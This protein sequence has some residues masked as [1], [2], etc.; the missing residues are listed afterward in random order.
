MIGKM[1]RL[2][3]EIHLDVSR[4]VSETESQSENKNKGAAAGGGG[5]QRSGTV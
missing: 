3:S 5:G 4:T 1:R 2:S